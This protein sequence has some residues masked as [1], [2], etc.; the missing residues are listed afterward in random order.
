MSDEKSFIPY[1]NKSAKYAAYLLC[2]HSFILFNFF[3]LCLLQMQN[4]PAIKQPKVESAFSS[5]KNFCKREVQEQQPGSSAQHE[6]MDF[7]KLLTF[8]PFSG[9]HPENIPLCM[10]SKQGENLMD[11]CK[12]FFCKNWREDAT[13][14]WAA[15]CWKHTWRW[16]LAAEMFQHL[17]TVMW[18]SRQIPVS[19]DAAGS[20]NGS[21]LDPD[22]ALAWIPMTLGLRC[23]SALLNLVIY[24]VYFIA[25]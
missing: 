1:T 6:I 22:R 3:F 14:V 7:M 25:V 18:S 9:F 24:L 21:I 13:S 11:V 4:V 8:Y 17:N 10:K 16:G 23:C 2:I 12:F 5:E 15:G 19:G 20:P